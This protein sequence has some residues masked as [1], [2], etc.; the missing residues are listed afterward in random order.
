MKPPT[1]HH[2]VHDSYLRGW[3]RDGMLRVYDLRRRSVRPS[4]AI[5]TGGENHFNTF[6]PDPVVIEALEY[7]LS[8]NRDRPGED[9]IYAYFVSALKAAASAQPE[10]RNQTFIEARFNIWESEIGPVLAQLAS[11]DRSGLDMGAQG[12]L[13]KL[14]CMQIMRTPAMR[15]A[16]LGKFQGHAAGHGLDARQAEDFFKLLPVAHAE[17]MASTLMS[18]GV[19]IRLHNSGGH[20]LLSSDRPAALVNWPLR[21][22]EDLVGFM[23]LSPDLAMSIAGSAQKQRSFPPSTVSQARVEQWNHLIIDCADTLVFLTDDGQV[24]KYRSRL[25]LRAGLLAG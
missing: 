16:V 3:E 4:K 22:I 24:E 5:N 12:S 10:Q 20:E 9:A 13:A 18:G 25:Q 6:L 7:A 23:P 19:T 14:F 11:G 1:Y 8:G 21:R 17:A 15:S 2:F